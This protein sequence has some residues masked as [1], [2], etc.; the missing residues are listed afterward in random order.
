MELRCDDL[1]VTVE[2]DPSLPVLVVCAT[3]SGDS[4]R[5]SET[6]VMVE[7]ARVRFNGTLAEFCTRP[8]GTTDDVE[9]A[10]LR[11]MFEAGPG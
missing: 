8:D 9:G 3:R 11:R 4:R 2:H 6:V 5:R 7:N 10:F 1:T